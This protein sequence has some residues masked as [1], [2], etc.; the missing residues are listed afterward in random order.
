MTREAHI[1]KLLLVLLILPF[2][3]NAQL[4]RR[5]KIVYER[6]TNI[7]KKMEG[8]PMAGRINESNKIMVED[9][10]LY[11]TDTATAFVPVPS[12]VQNPFSWATFKNSVYEDLRTHR[13]TVFMDVFGTQIIIS[14]SLP[15]R[16]WNITSKTRKI[17]GY[18]CT[19]AIWKKDDSTRIYAW[20][21]TDIVPVIGPETVTG[22]PG[23]ILGLA[24]EDGGV[25][26]FAKS[27]EE[28]DPTAEQMVMPK[29]KGKEYTDKSLYDELYDRFKNEPF[30]QRIL[31]EM[32][33]W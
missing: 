15:H 23:A 14:D 32:F 12:E 31:R 25:T 5:G 18:E 16:T 29:K 6:K 2:G 9:F 21:T 1:I 10:A 26:Y 11:F 7:L 17:A 30:G 19:R 3:T 4:I 24:T 28:Q 27:V 13:K 33:F 8:S 22:L 20:F